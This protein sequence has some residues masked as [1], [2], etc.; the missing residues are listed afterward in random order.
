[1]HHS[2]FLWLKEFHCHSVTLAGGF[3]C[4]DKLEG[5]IGFG[6]DI[7][8]LH[9]GIDESAHHLKVIGLRDGD[10]LSGIVREALWDIKVDTYTYNISRI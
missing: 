4:P 1:L 7:P 10:T 8:T 5:K 3:C 2:E 6:R 9:G